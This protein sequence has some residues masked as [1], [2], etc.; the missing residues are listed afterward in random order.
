MFI[1]FDQ[2]DILGLPSELQTINSNISTL[3]NKMNTVQGADN[4]DGSILKALKDA[5]AYADS[6]VQNVDLSQ[7]DLNKDALALLNN[8]SDAVAGS[9]AYANAQTL[10]AAKT[11]TDTKVGELADG[12]VTAV[13]TLLTTINGDSTVTGSFRKVISD[14]VNGAPENF[15]TLKEIADYLA[16]NGDLMQ[17]VT[18]MVNANISSLRS[19]I[20]GDVD[21]SMDTLGEVQDAIENITKVDGLIAVAKQE[22]IDASTAITN[23]AINTTLLKANNLSDLTNVADA[24]NT[25]DVF[26]KQETLDLFNA[27]FAKKKVRTPF[28]GILISNDKINV[29]DY[30][31]VTDDIHMNGFVIVT[32]PSGATRFVSA[33]T[34]AV[35]G[36]ILL[37]P[38]TPGELDGGTAKVTVDVLPVV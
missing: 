2:N 5:K 26:N 28:N 10:V 7:V 6:L 25:L 29:G 34:T 24:R 3:T 12:R 1:Q 4:V 23:A 27:E 9:V 32:M 8:P 22:A 36:E 33:V 11:Y 31:F 30:T 20:M 15:D 37:Q 17:A 35:T 21:E 13:E 38:G 19:E 14:V 18:T 16:E